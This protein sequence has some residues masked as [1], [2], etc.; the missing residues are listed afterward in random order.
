MSRRAAVKHDRQA[1]EA[2][3]TPY[4]AT[5]L[6]TGVLVRCG[7]WGGGWE[8]WEPAAG[9]GHVAKVL[10]DSFRRTVIA[11][12]KSPAPLADQVCAVAP[13]DF[14]SS[15]GLSG[16][17]RLAIITNPPYGYQNRLALAFLRHALPIAER[18]SGLVAMLLPFEFDQPGSRD[19][20]VGNHPAFAAKITSRERLRW[21]NLP[22]SKHPPLSHHSWF[23]W[24]F[25]RKLR[26]ALRETHAMRTL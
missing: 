11:T 5:A 23:V 3:Y 9:A 13:L 22:Q 26:A 1:N 4:H 15:M 25:D 21:V 24:S 2:Y 7:L 8:F 16:R 12:D 20:L 18:R 17:S 10:Q 14:L 19:E 6:L